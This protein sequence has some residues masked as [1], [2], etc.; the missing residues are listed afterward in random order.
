MALIVQK[1]GGTSVGSIERIKNVAQLVKAERDIGNQVVVVV[2]AMSGVTDQLVGL[3]SQLSSTAND[4]ERQ[5][6]DSVVSTGENVSSGLVALALMNLG[7]KARSW[8]GW[9]IPIIT[10]ELFS[11]GKI[12][13]I[14]PTKI[15]QCLQDN[16]IPVISGFQG[17]YDG[18]IVTLGRGG[19]DT[20]AAAIAAAINADRCDIY[21]DVD[22]VYTADPRVVPAAQKLDKI[23]Y[24]EMLEMAAS[25]A[26]VLHPRS[27]EIAEKY[28]LQMQVLSSIT[29]GK[30]TLLVNENDSMESQRITG[31]S[32]T[33]KICT[34]TIDDA[35]KALE[36]FT[37]F[38][39]SN[40][41]LD[42]FNQNLGSDNLT[43]IIPSHE[44]ILAENVLGKLCKYSVNEGFAKISI[45]G[46]GLQSSSSIAQKV[47]HILAEQGINIL[48]ITTTDIKIS[49]LVESQFMETAMQRL[50]SAFGLDA[51]KEAL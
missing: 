28:N 50:H 20:S 26:K 23:T 17:V 15:L 11:Q 24:G 36:I 3:V 31:V 19:S 40:V 25:G 21:T 38:N 12:Q 10:N 39:I 34:F 37:Q 16:E 9:Q 45:T 13:G 51:L 43:I 5:E 32:G 22:G 29:G 2:S 33:K 7:F 18:R 48:M 49:I 4:N 44:K 1:F 27:V 8:Q 46:S 35:S 6:Y 42:M 30:G 14:D 47:F 41:H